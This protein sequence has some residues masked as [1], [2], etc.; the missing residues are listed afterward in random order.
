MQ[1]PPTGCVCCVMNVV[2]V[3]VLSVSVTPQSAEAVL[4]SMLQRLSV[5]SSHLPSGTHDTLTHVSGI[6]HCVCESVVRHL[7]R[8]VGL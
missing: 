7:G 8:V 3:K 4:P 1:P 6:V 2:A 5:L